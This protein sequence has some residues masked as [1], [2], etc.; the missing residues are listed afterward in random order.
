MKIT[1]VLPDANMLGGTRVIAIYAERLQ[2]RGH[3]LCVVSTPRKPMA[4]RGRVKRLLTGEG[5]KVSTAPGPSHLDGLAIEHRVLDRW[6]GVTNADVPDAD[7][8]M[9][10][11]WETARPVAELSPSKGAKAYFVQDYGAHA[12][13]PLDKVAETWHLPLYKITISRWLEGLMRK[14]IGAEEEIAY[15]PNS[16]DR[17]QFFAPP[18]GK[19]GTPT[20]GFIYSTRPQK[21]CAAAMA[22]LG[23]ARKSVPELRVVAFGHGA[24]SDELPLIDGVTYLPNLAESRL[25][26]VY[27]QCDAWLFTSTLEGFGLPILEAMACRTPVIA[28][29]AG[30]APELLGGG[31]GMLVPPADAQAIA[32]AIGRIAA[33]PPMDWRKLSDA[34]HQ[35]A[36]S[37]SWDDATSGFELALVRVGERNAAMHGP[38]T[39]GRRG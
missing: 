16:V 12:G 34:A 13:Q 30:A 6:R 10:T 21:G 38:V 18:R 11:W 32:D 28:T 29:P 8:V 1:F 3:D 17:E 2:R 15:V 9:A 35:T 23:I 24:P 22:A 36:T 37:Y 25:R 26:E 14:H 20:V 39:S 27:A 7:V 4:L 19:Q 5:R 31:G 33:M